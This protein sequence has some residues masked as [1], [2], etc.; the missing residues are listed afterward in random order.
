MILDYF[1][2]THLVTS[3]IRRKLDEQTTSTFCTIFYVFHDYRC[4]RE[5]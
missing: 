5:N 1:F 3:S 2:Y 4:I